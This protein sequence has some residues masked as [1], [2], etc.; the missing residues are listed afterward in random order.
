VK[1]VERKILK[2]GA[3]FDVVVHTLETDSGERLERE[4]IDHPGSVVLAPML[5]DGRIVLIRNLRHSI[6]KAIIELPA[7][8]ANR[9][10]AGEAT[11]ARELTEETGYVA[12]RLKLLSEF[13]ACPGATTEWMRLYLADQLTPGP[14]QLEADEDITVLPTPLAEAMAM[15][16]D[17]RICDAKT[18]L[19]IWYAA[20]QGGA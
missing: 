8:T 5:D 13:Y 2:R 14:T 4:F 7:G 9:G 6:G 12:G 19:G 11:A 10:E 18:I 1:V 15:T 16:Q 20:R 17:G 3:K